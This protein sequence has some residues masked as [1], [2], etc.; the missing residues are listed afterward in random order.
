MSDPFPTANPIAGEPAAKMDEPTSP[1]LSLP[2]E[3]QLDIFS[4]LDFP[5][6]LKFCSLSRF[7]YTTFHP[8]LLPIPE[9]HR[10][11][12]LA[13][14]TLPYRGMACFT[15]LRLRPINDFEW[16]QAHIHR[17]KGVSEHTKR[18]CIPCGFAK[19]E[20]AP[21]R[22]LRAESQR[23]FVCKLCEDLKSTPPPS[24]G[25]CV[26]CAECWD[27]QDKD[28]HRILCS[29]C[30]LKRKTEEAERNVKAVE[31]EVEEVRLTEE[32]ERKRANGVKKRRGWKKKKWAL[33]IAHV[34]S[35]GGAKGTGRMSTQIARLR[36]FGK[37]LSPGRRVHA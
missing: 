24:C 13:E 18:F 2:V 33:T 29:C 27:V 35:H 26:I 32:V 37:R 17:V 16:V 10:Y 11:L 3:L 36:G 20:Y 6:A 34:F 22:V 28:W 21:G 1:L 8:S 30:R 31:V 14:T 9:Q 7:T 12:R 4:H 19:G 25:R 15:C 23:I 5:S